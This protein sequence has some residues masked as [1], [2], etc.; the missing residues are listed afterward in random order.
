[1][2]VNGIDIRKYN[3]KQLT[4]EV[5][6][7]SLQTDYELI[8]G[9][10][11]PQEF[12]TDIPL[13]KLKLCLYF[14]GKNRNSIIRNMSALLEQFQKSCVLELDGYEGKYKAFATSTDYEKLKVK[15]RYKLNIE[16]EGYFY[17]KEKLYTFDGTTSGTVIRTGSRK[18]PATIEIYAKKQISNF[19]ICG[20]AEDIKI[21]TLEAGKTLVINGTDGTATI[22]GINAFSAVDLWEFPVLECEK[23][24]LTF[25]GTDAIVKV[26]YAPMW[27]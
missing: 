14:R 16:V 19:V 2:K 11:I 26:K 24:V 18:T 23:T 15:D 4:A 21:A 8:T 17:D 13:G 6:P 10:V 3:A 22:N 7:P 12:E 9:A 25:S 5:L 20:F 1:M 27:L